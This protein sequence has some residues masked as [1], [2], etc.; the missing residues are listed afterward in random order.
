MLL[1]SFFQKRLTVG[2]IGIPEH[3]VFVGHAQ[4]VERDTALLYQAARFALRSKYAAAR[5]HID[6][7][8]AR[9]ADNFRDIL[10]RAAAEKSLRRAARLRGSLCAVYDFRCFVGK[11]FLRAIDFSALCRG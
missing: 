5:E 8:L 7:F 6:Q 11:D 1:F 2:E 4:V 9:G 10:R 3:I